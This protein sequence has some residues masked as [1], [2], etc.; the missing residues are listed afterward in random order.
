MDQILFDASK[1]VFYGR[2]SVFTVLTRIPDIT[3]CMKREK[4]NKMQQLDVYY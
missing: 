1:F 4:T 2:R 3:K